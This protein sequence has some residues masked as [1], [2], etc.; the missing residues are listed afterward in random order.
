LHGLRCEELHYA[1]KERIGRGKCGQ[2]LVQ[3]VRGG[4][5]DFHAEPL[6]RVQELHKLRIKWRRVPAEK[7]CFREGLMDTPRYCAVGQKHELLYEVV[8][9]FLQC[10]RKHHTEREKERERRGERPHLYIMA[11]R[12]RVARLVQLENQ[13]P[14]AER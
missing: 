4:C 5:V 3:R 14:I 10:M 13:F 1:E 8:R 12:D 9:V 11:N 2:R 7:R 6:A